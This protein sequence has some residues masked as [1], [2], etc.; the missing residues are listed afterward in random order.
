MAP[1][2]LPI[3]AADLAGAVG[4]HGQRPAHL[5][6]HHVVM[7]PAVAFQAGQAGAAAV[8][9]VDHMM[10]FAA[11]GRLVDPGP[12]PMNPGNCRAMDNAD[13]QG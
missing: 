8:G 10:G 13:R 11:G 7:P 6:Q 5:V 12:R 4:M 1:D 2:D 9:P 3:G